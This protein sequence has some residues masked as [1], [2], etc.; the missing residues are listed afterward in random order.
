MEKRR[1]KLFISVLVLAGLFYYS[2]H[3]ELPA[4]VNRQ[5]PLG[6]ETTA[7]QG[8]ALTE[9]PPVGTSKT[10][11]IL[12]ASESCL[13]VPLELKSVDD[14]ENFLKTQDI[15]TQAWNWDNYFIDTP[16][17]DKR[18]IHVVSDQ[19]KN[20]TEVKALK[21][22]R[23]DAD[24][25]TLLEEESFLDPAQFERALFEKQRSGVLTSKQ[26]VDTLSSG[27]GLEIKR[28]TQNG[29]ITDLSLRSSKGVLDC[30]F[31]DTVLS[32]SCK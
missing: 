4:V 12:A 8:T 9:A 23:E 14:F 25:P 10:E 7:P 17:G 26:T 11:N 30:R 3:S 19:N 5:M 15:S 31:S 29:I 2:R 16:D 18:T 1:V 28:T 6:P 24:G 21:V 20:G 32:C 22:F 13:G 27:K